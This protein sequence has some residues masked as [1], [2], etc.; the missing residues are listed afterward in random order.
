MCFIFPCVPI[1]PVRGSQKAS[2][3]RR[4]KGKKEAVAFVRQPL[5]SSFSNSLKS[6]ACCGGIS[7]MSFSKDCLIIDSMILPISLAVFAGSKVRCSVL[8]Q[9]Q[10]LPG[11]LLRGLQGRWNQSHRKNRSYRHI[12]RSVLQY[13]LISV[14]KPIQPIRYQ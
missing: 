4:K 11:L 1:M 6:Y 8:L 3:N 2:Q 10:S 14:R 9:R 7:L 13:H 12:F 5:Y